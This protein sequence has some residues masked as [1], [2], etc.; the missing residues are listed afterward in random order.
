MEKMLEE[1]KYCQNIKKKYFNQ[2]M[3]LTK[4]DKQNFKIA[5]QCHICNKNT[6]KKILSPSPKRG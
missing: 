1:V 4:E 5:D 6:I 3:I 2:D